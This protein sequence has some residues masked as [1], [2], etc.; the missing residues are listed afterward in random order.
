MNINFSFNQ[1]DTLKKIRKI[2]AV[3]TD[4]DGILTDGGIY[5]DCQGFELK[6]FN[7][8]DGMAVKLL[9]SKNIICA[10]ITGRFSEITIKRCK[11][12]CFDFHKHGI[13]NKL[14]EYENFKKKFNLKD[15]NILY[16]GDDINDIEILETCGVSVTASDSRS[17]IKEKVE[18]ITK[19]KG[20]EGVFRDITDLLLENIC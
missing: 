11:E 20:G 1:S 3:V 18:I 5:Y 19:S 16:L 12:L 14:I 2:K 8:K 7:V 17:Y 15:E 6:K 4:V 10:V 13:K 9:R